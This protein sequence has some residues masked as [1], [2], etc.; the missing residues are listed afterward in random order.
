M[1]IDALIVTYNSAGLI[2]ECVDRL[3]A[4]VPGGRVH[5]VDNCSFDGTQD[6]L[7]KVR[8]E[9][10]RLNKSNRFLS[11]EWNLFLRSASSEFVL[12][13][14]PDV[15]IRNGDFLQRALDAMSVDP[16]IAGAGRLCCQTLGQV[17]RWLAPFVRTTRVHS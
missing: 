4:V 12:L 2:Q 7:K 10:I 1:H 8:A 16:H 13:L 6:R 15:M 14:N 11:S 5:I 17:A 9:S 3:R